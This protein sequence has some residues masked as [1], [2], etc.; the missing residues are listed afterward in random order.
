MGDQ[1]SSR[2]GRPDYRSRG[3]I[4]NSLRNFPRNS[5]FW[6]KLQDHGDRRSHRR[7]RQDK[8]NLSCRGLGGRDAAALWRHLTTA[9]Y[10]AAS[11]SCKARRLSSKRRIGCPISNSPII[12]KTATATVPVVVTSVGDPV[13]AGL[14]AGL[15]RPGGNIRGD[16][17]HHRRADA[18]AA[19]AV[20]RAASPGRVIP[21][22][23]WGS[24]CRNRYCSAPMRSSNEACERLTHFDPANRPPGHGDDTKPIDSRFVL[25]NPDRL[26]YKYV[27]WQ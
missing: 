10:R 3:G 17:K 21:R 19:R 25:D 1:R 12:P 22:R 14:V 9:A 15:A 11:S 7:G 8:A 16:Q 2:R 5:R 13:A 27:W 20:V 26:R 24:A 4:R 18:Q 6:E 23:R